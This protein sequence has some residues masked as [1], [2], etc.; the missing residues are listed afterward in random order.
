MDAN[1]AIPAALIADPARA[2]IL[3]ALMDG[4][5]HPAST[6]AYAANLSPQAASNH[7]AKLLDGGMVL[8]EAEGRHRY[9]RLARPEIAAAL[10]ALQALAPRVRAIDEP[11]SPEARRLRAARTCYDH[12]AGRLGVAIA[13]AMEARGLL[14]APANEPA[15]KLYGLTEAGARWF[16]E[17]G[18]DLAAAM[19]RNRPPSRRCLD[20][21]ERRHHL[22]GPVGAALLR[23]LVELGWVVRN[24]ENRAVTVTPVGV[25]GLRRSL[26]ITWDAAGIAQAA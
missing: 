3:L 4:R 9:Y 10:E 6:L 19:G 2:A 26:G 23:R 12:L 15:G 17:L 14:S 24:A 21:T 25:E 8:V 22:A 20:W 18:V 7:L 16:A 11:R 1:I 13:Q 5:A